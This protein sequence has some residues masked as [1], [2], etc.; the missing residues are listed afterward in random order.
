MANAFNLSTLEA[1]VGRYLHVSQDYLVRPSLK[2]AKQLSKNRKKEYI[3][4]IFILEYTRRGSAV[5]E[6]YLKTIDLGKKI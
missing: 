4:Q 1:E 3:F 6:L 5:N 2:K